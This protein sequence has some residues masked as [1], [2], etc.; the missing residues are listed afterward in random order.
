MERDG[1]TLTSETPTEELPDG[2]VK[3]RR[4]QP[5]RLLLRPR[6]KTGE[7]ESLLANLSGNLRKSRIREDKF[8]EEL[9]DQLLDQE[10]SEEEELEELPTESSDIKTSFLRL[11]NLKER[12]SEEESLD[13]KLSRVVRDTSEDTPEDVTEESSDTS[14]SFSRT[15]PRRLSTR[16]ELP[17][18]K[19]DNNKQEEST[20]QDL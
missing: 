20:D 19:E 5:R 15:Q 10:S 16:E 6:S 14:K 12:S 17:C 3:S 13:T 1:T 9:T 11:Q 2:L 8:S 18:G 7:Q 4:L